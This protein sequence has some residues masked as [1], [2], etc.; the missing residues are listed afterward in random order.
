MWTF[1]TWIR[2]LL[3]GVF[4]YDFRYLIIHISK[5]WTP[6]LASFSGYFLTHVCLQTNLLPKVPSMYFLTPMN[7]FKKCHSQ[8]WHILSNF[9]KFSD[10]WST[11]TFTFSF[12][13]P[14]LSMI[15]TNVSPFWK[16]NKL[17]YPLKLRKMKIEGRI[18]ICGSSTN[19][20]QWI[21]E[22]ICSHFAWILTGENKIFEI[23]S[24]FLLANHSG[25]QN[26]L[27]YIFNLI[28]SVTIKQN[29]HVGAIFP[30]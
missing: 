14:E 28:G 23:F 5:T 15:K 4:F 24:I 2:V 30:I 7:L 13:V 17:R 12:I 19:G 8:F 22:K 20:K 27:I 3:Q 16:E 1:L 6:F 10:F 29:F 21:F 9:V 25:L 26:K 11:G 18:V